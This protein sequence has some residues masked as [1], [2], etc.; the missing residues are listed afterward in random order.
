M[1]SPTIQF[2]S[3]LNSLLSRNYPEQ[4]QKTDEVQYDQQLV[5]AVQSQGIA[6]TNNNSKN[7]R[8]QF[9]KPIPNSSQTYRPT[10]Y[11]TLPYQDKIQTRTS[12]NEII[13]H[14][15]NNNNYKYETK[16]AKLD[17]SQEQTGMK[18]Q[19]KNGSQRNNHTQ[20]TTALTTFQPISTLNKRYDDMDDQDEEYRP[21]VQ[22]KTSSLSQQLNQAS[23]ED[24]AI[25]SLQLPQSSI[26]NYFRHSFSIISGFPKE[27]P[28]RTGPLSSEEINKNSLIGRANQNY[29]QNDTFIS[30]TQR[31]IQ[32]NVKND[33][34][35]SINSNEQKIQNQS[36]G[37][38]SFEEKC[39]QGS[40][41]EGSRNRVAIGNSQK[42][43]NLTKTSANHRYPYRIRQKYVYDNM[44][45]CIDLLE[46]GI[47]ATKF[48]YSNK[49]SKICVV[50]INHDFDKL[51]WQY[52]TSKGL[53]S[54]KTEV[55]LNTIN[56][57]VYGAFTCTFQ[58]YQ[59]DILK[60]IYQK[61][62]QL[63]NP[64]ATPIFNGKQE[65]FQKTAHFMKSTMS[66][67]KSEQVLGV[68][69]RRTS[70]F[71]KS[72]LPPQE[73][74]YS[75]Q[76]VSLF[77]DTR[78]IDFVFEN[79]DEMFAFIQYMQTVVNTNQ[80]RLIHKQIELSIKDASLR[81]R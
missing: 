52:N 72:K 73:P 13:R 24:Q 4:F 36:F 17:K 32:K 70:F 21:K 25:T 64:A 8:S 34:L 44:N 33:S 11:S 42:Q 43:K 69:T 3:S 19:Q 35:E 76:C 78:T 40:F 14:N 37:L 31:I 12:N 7:N 46:R 39:N 50:K 23:T 15:Q 58:Q 59:D 53:V 30:T 47:Q 16:T 61:N 49:M 79:E 27:N 18:L 67:S 22:T 77:T 65:D 54:K 48:H 57:F 9:S 26:S 55:N 5:K 75:W 62:R 81:E 45:Y 29:Q 56:G 80:L 63:L 41:D 2:K 28:S 10:I 71:G 6:N 1:N 38:D 66:H 60:C 74:F 68:S 51:I 20:S